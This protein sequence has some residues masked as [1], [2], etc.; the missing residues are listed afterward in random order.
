MNAEQSQEIYAELGLRPV[1]NCSGYQL[2]VLGGSILSPTVR[3]AMEDANR[4]FV[5]MK[6]ML[7]RSGKIIADL[8]GAEAALVTAGCSSAMVLG[9]AAC[10]A[11]RDPDRRRAC[12]TQP[13]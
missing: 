5:D 3:Q 2:T 13:A 10:M 1:I 12:P 6:E 7:E 9:I 4:Y 8:V 11:G